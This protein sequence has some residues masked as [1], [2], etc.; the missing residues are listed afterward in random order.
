M[1]REL[2]IDIAILFRT[3]ADHALTDRETGPDYDEADRLDAIADE[4]GERAEGRAA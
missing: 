4:L 1:T 3:E 2:L